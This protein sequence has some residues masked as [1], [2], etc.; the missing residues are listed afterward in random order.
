MVRAATLLL[1]CL[2]A[3]WSGQAAAAGQGASTLTIGRLQEEIRSHEDLLD[4]SGD[5]ERSL[6]DQLARLDGDISRQQSAIRDIQARIQAQDEVLAAKEAELATIR[7]KNKTL[8]DH[9]M[10]RLRAFY[11]MG[12]HGVLNVAFS[13][14]SLPE[15]LLVND[16]F[17]S[18]VTYDQEV[19]AAYRES[20][21]TIE[22]ARQARELE[23]AVHEKFLEEADREHRELAATVAEKNELLE[24]VRTRKGLYEQALREMRKAEGE[25]H[26][27]LAGRKQ[28]KAQQARGFAGNRGALPPPVV[29]RLVR[30][31][32]DPAYAADDATFQNG[33]TIAVDGR[34]QVR[35]VYGGEVIFAGYMRGYGK[36]VIIDHDLQYCT[37]SAR[38]D[39]LAVREGD[40]VSQ[41]QVLGTT[42]EVATLFGDGL[43]F[44][45]RRG[46]VAEDP[47]LW[48]RT[49]AVARR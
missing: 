28:A 2:L 20:V 27:T 23:K 35:A 39:D 29:G 17:R 36:L 22:R 42:G 9:L 30:R 15:L 48:F 41:G 46:T 18:L 4:Q 26:K 37:V 24:Q 16:S 11:L 12:P 8:Q 3:V 21:T 6:L 13:S 49:G 10:K 45:I 44:E 33:I 31:F 14:R 43:Y 40:R 1:A 38:F 47:L 7:A 25:L 5:E 19:F 32:Q 34:T